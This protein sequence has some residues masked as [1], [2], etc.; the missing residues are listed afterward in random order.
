MHERM[1]SY[2]F[3]NCVSIVHTHTRVYPCVDPILCLFTLATNLRY[4][5]LKVMCHTRLNRLQDTVTSYDCV[6]VVVIALCHIRIIIVIV[7]FILASFGVVFVRVD[8]DDGQASCLRA[9]GPKTTV[10]SP[11][12]RHWKL[13]LAL[14]H[15]GMWSSQRS[16]NQAKSTPGM[17]PTPIPCNDFPTP[18][19][20][21]S[22]DFLRMWRHIRAFYQTFVL[23]ACLSAGCPVVFICHSRS[24][25][26]CNEVVI[27]LC[28][29]QQFW[30]LLL[31]VIRN[32]RVSILPRFWRGSRFLQHKKLLCMKVWRYCLWYIVYTHKR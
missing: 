19:A 26:R 23:F 17:G 31:W 15:N 27:E 22:D 2:F 3:E 4:W 29:H 7:C 11:G 32:T 5:Q 20:V 9:N 28:A 1:H 8:D 21:S 16:C 14:T 6:R 24:I 25:Y 18:T 30:A 12:W 10:G 13:G